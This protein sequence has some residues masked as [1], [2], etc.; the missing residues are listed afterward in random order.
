[1]RHA[2]RSGKTE[3]QK[4]KMENRWSCFAVITSWSWSIRLLH[5]P[6]S[7]EGSKYYA[8]PH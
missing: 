3:K 1:M 5:L 6:F 2:F 8:H 7:N 4:E